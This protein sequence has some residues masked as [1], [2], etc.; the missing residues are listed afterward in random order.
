MKAIAVIPARMNSKRIPH[1]NLQAITAGV[2]LLKQTII[3]ADASGV[4]DRIIIST[5]HVGFAV[6]DIFK[7]CEY[8]K[9]N[10]I[11]IKERPSHLCGDTTDISEVVADV[12]KDYDCKYVATLQPATP[13]RSA[14]L[15]QKTIESMESL[16]CNGAI[17][18]ARLVPWCWHIDK[19]HVT[20]GW[21]PDKYPRSQ[22]VKYH[23]LQEIN[24]LQVATREVAIDCK[25]WDL[26]LLMVELPTWATLDIDE[27][28]E[29]DEAR[30]LW[31]SIKPLFDKIPRFHMHV[32][33]DINKHK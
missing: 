17:T 23:N 3:D 12:A 5:D 20:N 6:D 26:P 32:I 19:G 31:P 29:L 18:A 28:H 10:A 13:L 27:Q 22:D 24:T 33:N 25:R 8:K 2:S 9:H 21:H 30:A 14:N 11:E 7:N 4:F 16:R 1:K 15:I